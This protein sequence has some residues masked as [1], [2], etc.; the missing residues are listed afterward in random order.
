MSPLL[1]IARQVL[2]HKATR[3][4]AVYVLTNKRARGIAGKY[5]KQ[6]LQKD[7][8]QTLKS[9]GREVSDNI[10]PLKDSLKDSL[11]NFDAQ[12]AAQ[13]AGETFQRVKRQVT[14]QVKARAEAWISPERELAVYAEDGEWLVRR[15]A[16]KEPLGRFADATVALAVAALVAS[17][18][19]G[20]GRVYVSDADGGSET[21]IV[22]EG[23]SPRDLPA[24][25]V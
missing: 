4:A 3:R 23:L 5:A 1:P 13:T 10:L 11:K 20:G 8:A 15:V 25:R 7:A 24:L 18:H 17:S 9:A 19:P 2:A 16:R 22:P 21:V 6:V 12:T 14:E